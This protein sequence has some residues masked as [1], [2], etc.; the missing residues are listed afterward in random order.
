MTDPLPPA[1]DL[2]PPPFAEGLCDWSRGD[3]TADLAELRGRRGRPD[4]AD[5]ADFGVCLEL[6]KV[7]TVQRLRYMGEVP[8]RPGACIEIVVRIKA[9]RGPLP[10]GADRR[11][12][13]RRRRRDPARS[14]GR[15]TGDGAG[16]ARRG[17][18]RC[19][20]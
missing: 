17:D 15:R 19:A 3:G 16:R 10:L 8:L 14:A 5:D 20:R 13:G 12:G 2:T 1:L 9:L 11:L 18:A 6:R 7:E 4:R